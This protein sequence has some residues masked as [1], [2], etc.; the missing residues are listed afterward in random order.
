MLQLAL[1]ILNF[2]II[3]SPVQFTRPKI[4]SKV[5]CVWKVLIHLDYL[6]RDILHL[7]VWK[8]S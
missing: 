1:F 6:W 4:K 2:K 3:V 5:N 7:G 8:F